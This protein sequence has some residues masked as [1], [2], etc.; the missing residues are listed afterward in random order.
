MDENSTF[1]FYI[2]DIIGNVGIWFS[3]GNNIP[4]NR[5]NIHMFSEG[6]SST[7]LITEGNITTLKDWEILLDNFNTYTN[8]LKKGADITTIWLT[9]YSFALI[10]RPNVKYYLNT[11]K[12]FLSLLNKKDSQYNEFY[13]LLD[14][15]IIDCSISSFI[16]S[17]KESGKVDDL[18][19]MLKTKWI[20]N[21]NNI[22]CAS[23]YF[24]N[25]NKKH[26]IIIGIAAI[27]T[28]N[29]SL[30]CGA[31]SS[32]MD[33]MPYI[34]HKY[35]KEYNLFYKG[36]PAVPITR[37][38]DGRVEYFKEHNISVLPNSVPMET[39]MYLYDNVYIGGYYSSTMTNSLKNQT[40][41]FIADEN[42]LKQEPSIAPF[43]NKKDPEYKGIFEISEF[44]TTKNIKKKWS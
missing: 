34:V 33:F 26:L 17:V 7:K 5:F 19:F 16:Q 12:G 28:E 8:Y 6:F 32:L 39:Y 30:N 41:F 42:T 4:E 22:G 23:D 14:S 31:D 21:E 3:Y 10:S 38:T 40:L 35:G 20:D 9:K 11:K 29:N 44:L 27:F 15:T 18:E 43:F 36:H 13:N 25:N 37:F 2:D 24:V 1:D